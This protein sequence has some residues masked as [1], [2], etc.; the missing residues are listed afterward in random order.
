MIDRCD[1]GVRRCGHSVWGRLRVD[2]IVSTEK[3][4]ASGGAKSGQAQK[5]GASA[6][7]SPPARRTAVMIVAMHR[8]GTSALSRA[9]NL[10]G[11]DMPPR[12]IDAHRIARQA[13][14]LGR[15]GQRPD[16]L[17]LGLGANVEIAG[18]IPSPDIEAWNMLAPCR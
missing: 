5:V 8:S 16:D 1:H 18:I 4:Q 2:D 9:L 17:I 7:V 3:A 11:C 6:P 12:L 13:I 10:L 14:A 15:I